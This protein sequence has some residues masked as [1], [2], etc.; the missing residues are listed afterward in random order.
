MR[1]RRVIADR[2]CARQPARVEH[3]R[4]SGFDQASDAAVRDLVNNVIRRPLA[5]QLAAAHILLE[6]HRFDE[7]KV[8][9]LSSSSAGD[10][11]GALERDRE[12]LGCVISFV[13][14][15]A[16]WRR[17]AKYT[18]RDGRIERVGGEAVLI[19]RDNSYGIAAGPAADAV[20]SFVQGLA[21]SSLT[22]ERRTSEGAG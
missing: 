3:I 15:Q 11:L 10:G 2:Y 17:A 14:G 12:P 19:V 8:L 4:A 9:A 18:E 16:R 1:A 21:R 20:R 6:A 22:F 5:N 7:A 13:D